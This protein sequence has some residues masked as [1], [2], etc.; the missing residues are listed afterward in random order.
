M[1]YENQS[2][3]CLTWN[4][5]ILQPKAHFKP[6]QPNTFVWQKVFFL[7]IDLS[8]QLRGATG[9]SFQQKGMLFYKTNFKNIVELSIKF[10]YCFKKNWA[11]LGLFFFIFV[12]SIQLSVN[13]Q[14]TF[15]PMTGLE[16]CTSGIRCNHS[17]NWASTT[18]QFH[19]FSIYKHEWWLLLIS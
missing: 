17:T 1:L 19:S 11:I 15:L 4:K 14:Y 8:S 12:F 6:S 16:Q 9:F 18:V 13:V 3:D 7:I 10:N 2:V 5:I